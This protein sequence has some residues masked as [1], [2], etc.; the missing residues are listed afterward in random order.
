M[1]R[2]E[3]VIQ[4]RW[5]VHR[6]KKARGV[7][8][9]SLVARLV[10]ARACKRHGTNVVV[11]ARIELGVQLKFGSGSAASVTDGNCAV[12]LQDQD[13]SFLRTRCFLRP[14]LPKVG[15]VWL[16]LVDICFIEFFADGPSISKE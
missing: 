1:D 3:D 15:K 12:L 5:V 14:I 7:M 6:A 2:W 10:H 4:R 13:M 11:G 16:D 8:R 9:S